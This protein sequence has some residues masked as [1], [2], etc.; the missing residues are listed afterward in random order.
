[1]ITRSK[2]AGDSAVPAGNGTLVCV[3]AKLHHLTGRE[4]YLRRAEAIVKVFAG[5]VARNFFPLATLLNASEFLAKPLQIVIRGRREDEGVA[6]LRHAV[7]SVSLPNK[8]LAVLGPDAALPP[9]HP[10]FGKE[11]IGGRPTVYICEG[12]VCSLPITDPEALVGDL[13]QRR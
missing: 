11:M 9:G 12:P 2:T 4:A 1:L 10:A 13:R 6:A 5:E 7:Y 8:I 3:L